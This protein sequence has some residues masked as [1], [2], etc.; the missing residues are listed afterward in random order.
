M[1]KKIEEEFVNTYIIKNKRER[2]LFE[3]QNPKRREEAVGRFCHLTDELLIPSKIT[4]KGKYILDDIKTK[5]LDS[6][7]TSCY[8][9]SF[10]SDIDGIELQKQD[11][12]NEIIGMG[13]PSIAI[14]D[15]FVIIE[16][17]QEQGPA[18]KY[19]LEK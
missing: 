2:L 9:I 14:F 11:V 18:V 19:L 16:T 10:F 7:A 5:I 4:A 8:V 13:M 6:N 12:I 17:E 3:L 1:N 15:D